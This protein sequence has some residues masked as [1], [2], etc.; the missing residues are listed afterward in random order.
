MLKA[1]I[2]HSSGEDR[3]R[4]RVVPPEAVLKWSEKLN[5]MK[6]EIS[7]ILQEEK[8]EKHVCRRDWYSVIC[9]VKVVT[10]S[11]DTSSRDGAQERTEYDRARG[12]D[13][14]QAS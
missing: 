7:E 14:L 2:K 13:L 8:E 6:D 4:H 5:E 11:T 1:A 9:V 12:G 10:P 3:V